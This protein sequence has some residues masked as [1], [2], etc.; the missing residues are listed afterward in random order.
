MR[1]ATAIILISFFCGTLPVSAYSASQ[2]NFLWRIQSKSSTVFLLGSIHVLKKDAYPLSKTIEDAF[3]K[4]DALAVE[5]NVN[6]VKQI[7]INSLL[8][9]ALYSGNDNLEKH[10]TAATYSL[11]T[12][13]IDRL[14]LPPD[15]ALKQKPW[16]LGLTL[17]SLALLNAGYDPQ[18]GIDVHF[19]AKAEGKKKILEL[20]SVDQQLDLLSGMND[21][22]QEIFLRYSLKDLQLVAQEADAMV[23]AWKAGSPKLLA[24]ILEKSTKDDKKFSSFFYDRF[25]W[26]RNK[27]ISA[28]IKTYLKTP[29]TY[30]VVVGA[31]HLLG[32]Q[33][34]IELLKNDGYNVDH[35]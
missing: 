24:A 16:F 2:K 26:K 8:G 10:I 31:A 9:N 34:I 33:G 18:Y 11:V 13:E 23:K 20:E 21:E 32:E 28:V 29:G 30:F 22:E 5:A 14:G 4:S 35:L 27:R 6:D 12:Q 1:S 15:L 7:D 25:V 17:Q 19:L 3:E